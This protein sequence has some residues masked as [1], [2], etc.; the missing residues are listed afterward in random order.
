MRLSS[1]RHVSFLVSEPITL[2]PVLK[3]IE[4][5]VFEGDATDDDGRAVSLFCQ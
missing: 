3:G 2:F 4:H 1:I 5:S